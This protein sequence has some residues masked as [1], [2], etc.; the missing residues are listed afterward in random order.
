MNVFLAVLVTRMSFSLHF[1]PS[2]YWVT[3]ILY[4]YGVVPEMRTQRTARSAPT[5][6]RARTLHSRP[7]AALNNENR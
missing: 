3:T 7:I 1:P 4:D 2:F 6:F 5:R